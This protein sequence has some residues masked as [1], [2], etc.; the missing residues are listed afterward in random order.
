[1]VIGVLID[2]DDGRSRSM[3]ARRGASIRRE[4]LRRTPEIIL[5]KARLNV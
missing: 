1:M 5:Y 3:P 4:N 2:F